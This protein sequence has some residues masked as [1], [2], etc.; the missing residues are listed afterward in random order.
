MGTMFLKEKKYHVELRAKMG[1]E[2]VGEELRR[3][4]LK[5]SS[6]VLSKDL[7]DLVKNVLW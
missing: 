6:Q 2:A 3:D 1:L 5:C 7:N 4:R